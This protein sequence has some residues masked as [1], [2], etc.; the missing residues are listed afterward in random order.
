M[1]GSVLR[2]AQAAPRHDSVLGAVPLV[3][4]VALGALGAINTWDVPVYLGLLGAGLFYAGYRAARARGLLV[5]GLAFLLVA[6][7]AAL[8]YSPFYARYQAQYVGLAWVPPANVHPWGHF[9]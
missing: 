5:G 9:C 1:R 6:V 3:L 8:L 2:Y 7:L 4:A